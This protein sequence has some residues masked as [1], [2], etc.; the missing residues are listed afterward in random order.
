MA[1][2]HATAACR[3]GRPGADAVPTAGPAGPP[4]ELVEV[5]DPADPRLADYRD[6]DDAALRRRRGADDDVVVVEGRVAV[7]QLL[8]SPFEIRS[9]LVD[10]H[11]AV[12]VADLVDAARS[13]GA[14]VFVG[15]RPVVAATVGF[16]LHRGV[17]AVAGRPDPVDAGRLLTRA[18]RRPSA[19]GGPPV[20]AVVEGVNDH[21]NLGALFRNAAAFGVA[22]VL[23]DPTCADP[24]YRRAVRVS[25]GHV[26][27]VPFARLSPWPDALHELR[28][29]GFAVAALV[30]R[31]PPPGAGRPPVG[32]G[33]LAALLDPARPGMAVVLGAEGPG[34]SAAA[35]AAADHVVTIPMAPGVDSLNVATAAAVTFHRLAGG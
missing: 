13:R 26:L 6:L 12:A 22:A 1:P 35:I 27:H 23:L 17:V 24:L 21:E 33:E 8:T 4:G 34:L 32:P 14:R 28:D 29:A 9:L 19:G 16:A 5:D 15:S 7:R 25:V 30:P 18:G 20:V 3:R 11:Q 31:P 2:W 10:D